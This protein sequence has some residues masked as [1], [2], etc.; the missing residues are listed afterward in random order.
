MGELANIF[1]DPS[2]VLSSLAL[3]GNKIS[4]TKWKRGQWIYDATIGP[5]PTHAGQPAVQPGSDP[6]VSPCA[7]SQNL[8][9]IEGYN[10]AKWLQAAG[11]ASIL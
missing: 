3:S 8:A 2:A 1:S 7:S 10:S 4:G 11:Q 9:V 6:Q 5:C